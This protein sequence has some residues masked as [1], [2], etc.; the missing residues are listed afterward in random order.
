V[1]PREGGRGSPSGG[2]GDRAASDLGRPVR[3]GQLEFVVGDWKCGVQRLG[4]GPLAR[5]PRGTFCLAQVRVRNI[6]DSARTLFEPFQKLRDSADRTH[7]ADFAARFYFPG[8]TLWNEVRP[9]GS[10][11]GTMVFDLPAG[12]EAVGLEL[13]DGIASGGVEV[14]L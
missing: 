13:H 4:S 12:A 1:L 8:Q 3:D 9:G 10:V 7:G 6:G 11:A 14:R 5:T 2:T